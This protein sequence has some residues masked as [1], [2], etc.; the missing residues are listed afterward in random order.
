MKKAEEDYIVMVRKTFQGFEAELESTKIERMTELDRK[1]AELQSTIREIK[2]VTECTQSIIQTGSEFEIV[3]SH[4][5]LSTRLQQLSKSKPIAADQTLGYIK[6]EASI[7]KNSIIGQ[8]SKHGIPGKKWK[9]TAQFTTGDLD[10]LLGLDV[11]TDSTNIIVGT[12]EKG[13]KIFSRHGKTVYTLYKSPGSISVAITAD[14]KYVTSPRGSMQIKITDCRGNQLSA[15]P[16][17]S[18]N[19]ESS[20]ANSFTVD[21]SGKIIVGQASNTISIHNADGTLVSKFATQF[22]P[23][24]LAATSNG[25]IVG[26]FLNA[27][28]GRGS[29]QLLDYSGGKVRVIQPPAEV[30]EWEPGF[31]C[32]G[33]GEIFVSNQGQGKPN[34]VYRYTSEGDYLGCVTTK[35]SNPKGI[36]LSRD[37]MELFVVARKDN[38][39]KIFKRP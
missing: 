37:G 13:V 23:L 17:K 14:E 24:R 4:T 7:P 26:S 5:T 30:E 28:S 32:C 31:V 38:Q 18:A 12:W 25:E 8:L 16:I 20:H 27:E 29:L 11:N 22:K 35:V 6:F 33:Q 19:N 2:S 15:S 36:A 10:K 9:S 39:V 21:S 34:G 1:E 3:S